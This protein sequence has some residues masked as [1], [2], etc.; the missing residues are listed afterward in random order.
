MKNKNYNNEELAIIQMFLNLHNLRITERRSA[1][2]SQN[3]LLK[4]TYY[5]TK[6]IKD[7][8]SFVSYSTNTISTYEIYSLKRQNKMIIQ[9]ILTEKQIQMI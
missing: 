2:K 8:T 6:P 1:E 9:K 3:G 7:K 4:I 5:S